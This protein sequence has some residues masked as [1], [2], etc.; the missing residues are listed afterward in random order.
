MSEV[1][2]MERSFISVKKIILRNTLKHNGETLLKYRIEYPEFGSSCALPCLET[3]NRLYMDRAL[4]YRRYC[5]TELFALAITQYLEDLANGFPVRIFEAAAVFEATYLNSCALSLY[6]DRY[7][8]AGGA[9]GKTARDS[10]TW[11]LRLCRLMELRQLVNCPP[12]H[13]AYVL[14]QVEA[15]IR[16]Q[17]DL[18]FENYG[19]LIVSTFNEK[20]FYATPK[21]ITV[22]YQQYDIAPYSSGIRDFLLPYSE[23]VISPQELCCTR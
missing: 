10:Q 3:I 18:Y 14:S 5:E 17:P 22:Y 20:N 6:T 1:M 19:E 12:C 15:Q 11:D 23:C 7:E 2:P 13:N 4:E 21:G 9:H 16:L 8:Y